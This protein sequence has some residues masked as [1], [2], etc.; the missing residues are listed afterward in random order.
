M[1]VMLFL[2]LIGILVFFV[3]LM[4]LSSPRRSRPG[5]GTGDAGFSFS[6]GGSWDDSSG[7]CGGGDSG[8]GD[9]GGGDGGGCGGG[10]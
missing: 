6:D 1:D 5:D 3:S 2:I 9:G 4:W 7:N 8:G 10:E